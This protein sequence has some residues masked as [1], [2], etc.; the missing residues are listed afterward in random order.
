MYPS[1]L[2]RTGAPPGP[3]GALGAAF[4]DVEGGQ[5]DADGGQGG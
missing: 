4:Q 2:Q 5:E 3:L 1:K